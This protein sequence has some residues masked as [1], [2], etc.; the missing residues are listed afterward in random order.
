MKHIKVIG[1]IAAI[2]LSLVTTAVASYIV[3][4]NAGQQAGYAQGNQEGHAQGY[5]QG[6]ESGRNEQLETIAADPHKL[7]IPDFTGLNASEAG[8]GESADRYLKINS[9]GSTMPIRFKTPDG[10]ALDDSNIKN[11]KVVDQDPKPGTIVD[12]TYASSGGKEYES[13]ITSMGISQ[14]TLVV[15]KVSEES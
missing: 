1:T 6:E 11:Y 12:I 7:V 10:S 2:I 13:I 15:E 9:L 8:S 14:I 5:A 3:G 4:S